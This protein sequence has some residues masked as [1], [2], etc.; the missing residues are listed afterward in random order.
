LQPG[1]Q[2]NHA[3]AIE[4]SNALTPFT[5]DL[6]ISVRVVTIIPR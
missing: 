1:L 3:C 6:Y 4:K 2:L 5:R